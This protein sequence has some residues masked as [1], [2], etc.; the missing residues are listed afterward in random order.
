GWSGAC[1]G[2]S[3]GCTVVM[4]ADKSLGALFN[5]VPRARIGATAYGTLSSAC[6]AVTAGQTIEIKALS[7]IGNLTLNRGL[8]ITLRGG[9]ADNYSGQTGYTELDGVLTVSSGTVTLDRIV[10]K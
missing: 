4:S 10:V 6:L 2:T 3:S 9:Y 1:S 7:F 5:L 8:N